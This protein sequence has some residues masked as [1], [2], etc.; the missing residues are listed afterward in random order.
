[1][2]R[3]FLVGGVYVQ[4][5]RYRQQHCYFSLHFVFISLVLALPKIYRLM[6]LLHQDL[7]QLFLHQS[8]PLLQVL[9]HLPLVRFRVIA[10]E[11][12]DLGSSWK[13]QQHLL[14]R[15]RVHPI[16]AFCAP[17]S[18]YRIVQN[19]R[20][21]PRYRSLNQ[22]QYCRFNVLLLHNHTHF[23]DS[24]CHHQLHLRLLQH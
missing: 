6:L 15:H 20:H 13:L 12:T 11:S 8:S 17:F 19:L 4:P 16:S 5:E 1:M 24:S 23:A 21:C 2:P 7:Q 9:H 14:V 22:D 18:S 3:S 10:E